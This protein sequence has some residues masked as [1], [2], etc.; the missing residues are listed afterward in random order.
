MLERSGLD[1]CGVAWLAAPQLRETRHRPTVCGAGQ[2]QVN[3]LIYENLLVWR[4]RRHVAD[5]TCVV[6]VPGEWQ[7]RDGG[8]VGTIAKAGGGT[9]R[10]KDE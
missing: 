1:H 9:I 3:Y 5:E 10:E 8:R 7:W 4:R 6:R 2:R